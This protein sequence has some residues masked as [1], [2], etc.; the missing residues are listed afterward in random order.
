[1]QADRNLASFTV[2]VGSSLIV[3]ALMLG[4]GGCAATHLQIGRMAERSGD[5]ETMLAHCQYALE[6]T[7][8]D[9]DAQLCV[10]DAHRKLGNSRAAEKAYLAY[11]DDRPGDVTA[12]LALVDLYLANRQTAKARIQIDQV[13][14]YDPRQAKAYYYRGEL[15]R[16]Q[17]ACRPAVTAYRK[18][19]E[20]APGDELARSGL[21]QAERETCNKPIKPGRKPSRKSFPESLPTQPQQPEEP[22]SAP[23]ARTP[24]SPP[25]RTTE[26]IPQ[27]PPAPPPAPEPGDGGTPPPKTAEPLP[28][29]PSAPP[30]APAPG[31]SGTAPAGSRPGPKPDEWL[32]PTKNPW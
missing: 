10:A 29:Q 30:P 24:A 5:Y 3:L 13:L 25:P 2:P 22:T 19:L 4:L 31:G 9:L 28:P 12:R 17:G 14:R 7:H 1:M 23:P 27:Q 20:L 11:L 18:A 15:E 8:Q 26:P 16:R 6:A 32:S 21:V